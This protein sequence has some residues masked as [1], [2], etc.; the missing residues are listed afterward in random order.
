MTIVCVQCLDY[1]FSRSVGRR[2]E[3]VMLMQDPPDPPEKNQPSTH[4]PEGDVVDGADDALESDRPDEQLISD[5][6]ESHRTVTFTASSAAATRRTQGA[7]ARQGQFETRS[8]ES[9]QAR[10]AQDRWWMWPL[11]S[12]VGLAA[13][14]LMNW[15]ANWIPLNDRETG[16]LA[17]EN[18]VPFQPAG[19]AFS[20][21]GVIYVLLFVYV[22]Y[23]FLPVGRQNARIQRVGPLFLVANIANI[24]WLLLWHYEAVG[25]SLVAMTILLA[26]LLG[27]YVILWH[28][29]VDPGRLSTLQ[30]LI[31]RIP[32]SVY[33]GWISIA[34]LANIQIWMSLGGWSGGPFGLQGWAVIFL[35]AGVLLAA[36]IAFFAHDAAYPLVF[37]WGYLGIAYE[38]WDDSRFISILA[39][40][41]VIVVAALVVMALLLSFDSRSHFRMPLSSRRHGDRIPPPAS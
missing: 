25:G 35:L 20:I 5:P 30:R 26:S 3:Q 29:T 2:Y 18:P 23:S 16:Q 17:N 28:R 9:T 22:V 24:S 13:V 15:L 40:L 33:L 1:L 11:I 39:I 8:P 31:V 7:N 14:V 38:Q 21:W 27:I 6:G 37:V 12:L 10:A 36:A 4:G 19:W 32:F 34:I 41:M